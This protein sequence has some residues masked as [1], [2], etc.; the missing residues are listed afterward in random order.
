MVLLTRYLQACVRSILTDL[1]VFDSQ[2]LFREFLPHMFGKSI[3]RIVFAP[4]L[5]VT[6]YSLYLLGLEPQAL[7]IDMSKLANPLPFGYAEGG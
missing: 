3:G 1:K 6:E 5:A 2:I 7:D 4:H